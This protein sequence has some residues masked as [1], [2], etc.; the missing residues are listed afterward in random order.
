MALFGR[1]VTRP[2]GTDR[3][4]PFLLDARRN[5]GERLR[6]RPDILSER[7]RRSKLVTASHL[8]V[9]DTDGVE[10]GE[11]WSERSG[12]QLCSVAHNTGIR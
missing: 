2:S 9:D 10:Q 7:D 5:V 1:P 3:N 4:S 11:R 12:S 6:I 8:R